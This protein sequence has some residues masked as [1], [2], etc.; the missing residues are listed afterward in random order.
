MYRGI[1]PPG[2]GGHL[3]RILKNIDKD[4]NN[5]NIIINFYDINY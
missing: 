1:H 5:I 2:Y 3:I 4:V